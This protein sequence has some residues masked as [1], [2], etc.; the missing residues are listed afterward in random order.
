[1]H[2]APANGLDLQSSL[3]SISTWWNYNDCEGR[4]ATDI[5]AKCPGWRWFGDGR[6]GGES[7]LQVSSGS[8]RVMTRFAMRTSCFLQWALLR[9]WERRWLGLEPSA[10]A[11]YFMVSTASLSILGHEHDLSRL[12]IQLW[13]DTHVAA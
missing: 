11:G 7:P 4:R 8:D 12:V 13:N 1:M 3:K 10:N 2:G 5:R 9:V 6:P